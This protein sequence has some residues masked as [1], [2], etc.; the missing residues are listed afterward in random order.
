MGSAEP[1]QMSHKRRTSNGCPSDD[2]RLIKRASRLRRLP[3]VSTRGPAVFPRPKRTDIDQMK[4]DVIRLIA[5]WLIGHLSRLL[6]LL[7]VT[8]P[9]VWDDSVRDH[10]FTFGF[11][12]GRYQRW[13][14]W[15][16]NTDRE[17]VPLDRHPP[18]CLTQSQR[19]T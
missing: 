9:Q 17:P 3:L 13:R 15:T 4:Q 6:S 14:G 18:L 5:D 1:S 2:Q 10:A 16:S 8:L 7:F 12:Y 19:N 11:N